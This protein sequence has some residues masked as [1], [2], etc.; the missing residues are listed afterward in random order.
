MARIKR[1]ECAIPVAEK[2]PRP[3]TEVIGFIEAPNV[4]IHDFPA[5]IWNS[6]TDINPQ[7]WSGVPG[8]Y[9]NL[10]GAGWKVTH[11]MTI[12]TGK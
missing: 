12:E 8:S 1:P 2:M 11:W 5:V 4:A 10:A 6:G 9:I 7:W 3:H